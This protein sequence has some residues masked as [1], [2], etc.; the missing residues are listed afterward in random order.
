MD[1]RLGRVHGVPPHTEGRRA[2]LWRGRCTV[3]LLMTVA[4]GVLVAALAAEAPPA[5][6][7][8]RI[9]W[10]SGL[11]PSTASALHAAFQQGLH[12]LGYVEGQNLAIEFRYAEGSL[13]R[14]PA[15]AAELVRLP[16]DVIV[17]GGENAARVAQHATHTIS[18]VIVAGVDPVRVGLV[19]S[20]ARP[21]GNITGLSSLGPE[22]GGKRLELLQEALPTASRVAV[23]L[24]PANINAVHEWREMEG[25]AQALGVQLHALAVRQADELES[26]F[27]TATSVGAVALI[28]FRDLFLETHRTR[29]LHLAAQRRLPVMSVLRDFVDAGGLMSYGPSLP[30][31]YRRAADYVHKLL[32]G[33]TPADLPVEQ[34]TKFK[35]V[36]NLRTAQALGVTFPPTLLFQADE[37]IR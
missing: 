37:V 13:D 22:L 14:L 36:L 31:L 2:A 35:L 16:V 4:L 27:T 17:T 30:D 11:A 18:I 7:M 15:L 21:E 12:E 33:A 24:N 5:G 10:L 20:L 32:T 9:G 28:V 25:A 1:T 8:Y 6:K 19:A 29:I 26:A 23:L 3:G 34:P